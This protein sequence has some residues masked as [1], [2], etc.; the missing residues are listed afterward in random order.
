M[1]DHSSEITQVNNICK[2]TSLQNNSQYESS[3]LFSIT[4]GPEFKMT[5]PQRNGP[6]IIR[7]Q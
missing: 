7:K 4:I 2:I 5:V 6:T 3:I 1:A